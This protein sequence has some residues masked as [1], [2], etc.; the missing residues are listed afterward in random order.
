[1]L[2]HLASSRL[3]CCINSFDVV[4]RSDEF[5]VM[6]NVLFR[7]GERR[8]CFYI[9]ILSIIL[10]NLFRFCLV[11]LIQ[12]VSSSSLTCKPASGLAF[13]DLLTHDS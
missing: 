6:M 10:H 13:T 5:V 7:M 3:L 1:M 2:F 9:S 4:L 11:L 8:A 12:L